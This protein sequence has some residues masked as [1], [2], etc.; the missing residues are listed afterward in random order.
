[1]A[2]LVFVGP[3]PAADGTTA[4]KLTDSEREEVSQIQQYLNS[5]RTL[6]ARFLQVSSNGAYSEGKLYIS[7]P[8]KLRIDYDPPVPVVI[9]TTG[10][11]LVYYDRELEQFSHVPLDQ[12]P[13]GLLV[14][15]K[16]DLFS[17]ELIITGFQLE[18]HTYRLSLV[19]ASDPLEGSLTLVLADRP[20]QLKKWEITDPQGVTTTVSLLSTRFGVELDDDLFEFR[21][22]RIF[23]PPKN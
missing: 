6:E 13:A 2:M 1:M 21:D 11:W 22:P 9:T 3:A 10:Q 23:G 20:M 16:I 12:T 14:R 19:R 18:A 5:I 8:G 17:K 7:R 15:K 4:V